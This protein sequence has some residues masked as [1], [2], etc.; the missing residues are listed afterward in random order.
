MN[1]WDERFLKLAQHVADW[2]K[3]PSTKI[4]CVI[5]NT[6]RIVVGMGYNGFPRGVHDTPERY[7]HRPTKYKIVQHAEANAIFNSIGPVIGCT[8]YTTHRPCCVCTGAL[9]QA[10]ISHV[11]TLVTDT[12]K[13]WLGDDAELAAQMF[14]EVGINYE[15]RRFT[16]P[17]S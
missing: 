14:A 10:G 7:N 12:D 4:G 1:H 3:D 16:H 2:S 6:N 11:I 13:E 5:V 8:A 15:E 17:T 9:I